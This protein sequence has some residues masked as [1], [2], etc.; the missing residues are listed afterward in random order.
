MYVLFAG[1]KVRTVKNYAQE[2]GIQKTI[3]KR[4]NLQNELA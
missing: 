4:E 3:K 1:R 2:F